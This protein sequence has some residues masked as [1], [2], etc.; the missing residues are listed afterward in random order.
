MKNK[1]KNQAPAHNPKKANMSKALKEKTHNQELI[2]RP[3]FR[4]LVLSSYR[5]NLK[6]LEKSI[7][8]HGLLNPLIIW[9]GCLVDGYHRY[10]VCKFHGIEIET[11]E[12]FFKTEQEA[13]IWK[14]ED[15][16]S[17]RSPC[18]Y[19]IKSLLKQIEKLE[20]EQTPSEDYRKE[21]RESY[22]E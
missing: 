17:R 2:T 18:E 10:D 5:E 21:Y 11:K 19:S 4:N 22:Y 12:M 8:E 15:S 16:L 6:Y 20:K 9:N 1:Q 7:L 3:L 13:A 14:I